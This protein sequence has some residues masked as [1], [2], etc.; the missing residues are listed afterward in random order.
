MRY[1][2]LRFDV[3]LCLLLS[4]LLSLLT[5]K[6]ANVFLPE[7]YESYAEEHTVAAGEIGGK[8]GDDVFQA[9]SVADLLVHDTF[10]IVSP[11]IEYRNRGAGFYDGRYLYAVTLPSGEVVA[12]HINGDSVQPLGESLMTGDNILPVGCVVYADLSEDETFMDQIQHALTLSRPDFYVDMMGEGGKV[13][14]EAYTEDSTALAQILTV[15]IAFPLI[16]ALGARLGIFPYFFAPRKKEEN[17]W[18]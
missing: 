11:G 18:D 4:V 8:A 9:Q 6:I 17:Q 13:S 1:H 3:W 14:Q 16:H 15:V 10:T 2:R 12:A 7:S 5:A